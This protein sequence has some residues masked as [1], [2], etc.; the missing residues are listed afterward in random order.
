MGVVCAHRIMAAMSELGLRLRAGLQAG[1]LE[2]VDV[3][4]IAGMTVNIAT[5]ISSLAGADELLASKL[6]SDLLV[7]S[8][9]TIRPIRAPRPQGCAVTGRDRHHRRLDGTATAS[10][11]SHQ[12]RRRWPALRSG[13]HVPRPDSSGRCFR[14]GGG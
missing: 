10:R 7:G 2:G 9:H 12:I 4:D 3:D 11:R 5:R 6:T 14:L 1:E 8:R 13:W